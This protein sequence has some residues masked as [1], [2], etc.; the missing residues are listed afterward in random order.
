[1]EKLL[2]QIEKQ[3]RKEIRGK[4]DEWLFIKLEVKEGITIEIK[5][6]GNWCQI[7]RHKESSVRGGGTY[8]STQKAVVNE[9]MNFVKYCL[10][11][12]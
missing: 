12:Y 2:K 7:L 6:Y 11:N 1:M 4:S 8:H 10:E 9:V 5:Q 3:Y